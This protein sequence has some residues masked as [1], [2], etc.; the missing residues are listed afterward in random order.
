MRFPLP[1]LLLVTLFA[2][3]VLALPDFQFGVSE[4]LLDTPNG[5]R[6]TQLADLDADGDL[7]LLVV[8]PDQVN[9]LLVY[10][11]DGAG[12]FALTQTSPLPDWGVVL[13]V[14]D[15]DGDGDLDV[16]VAASHFSESVVAFM[17]QGTGVLGAGIV[18]PLGNV[19]SDL[20]LA[21][22]DGDGNLDVV[23]SN[24]N[25]D[26]LSIHPGDGAGHF[27]A[28][29]T[30]PLLGKAFGLAVAD[31][32]GDLAPDIAVANFGGIPTFTL[33]GE[34]WVFRNDGAGGFAA[35]DSYDSGRGCWALVAGDMDRDG[36]L[37]LISTNRNTSSISYLENQ[38]GL[39]LPEVQYLVGGFPN[40][41]A[42]GDFDADG[43]LDVAAPSGNSPETHFLAGDGTGSLTADFVL[44]GLFNQ[45]AAT[46]GDVDGDGDLDLVVGGSQSVALFRNQT[47]QLNPFW[48]EVSHLVAGQTEEVHAENATP[49][50][51]SFL[52]VSFAGLVPELY[53]PVLDTT[54]A[55]A[56][57][58]LWGAQLT[59]AD[60]TNTWS[61]ALP[62]GLTGLN[63]WLQAFQYQASSFPITTQIQ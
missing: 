46:V 61:F 40:A 6:D 56:S 58:V 1:Q 2:P 27:A 5:F 43:D 63:L 9:G 25:S 59:G 45:S 52:A 51:V 28:G 10:T 42:L 33:P 3:S 11:N 44:P 50:S 18:T 34:V 23:L 15:L 55:L 57:P 49:F 37:D 48:I 54:V 20:A 29:T 14:G 41:T 4:K 19:V 47:P 36:D 31:F 26:T 21:D 39:F 53:L 12:N 13:D 60:G 7:D 17:N 16:V 38:G 30:I 35:H 32:D 62:P 22:F 24:W 8:L